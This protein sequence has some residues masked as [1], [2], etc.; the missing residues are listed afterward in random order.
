MPSYGENPFSIGIGVTATS[1]GI[2][3]S[4]QHTFDPIFDNVFASSIA[5]IPASAAT[6][7]DNIGLSSLSSA[8]DGN[9]AFPVVGI[10]LSVTSSGGSATMTLLQ[11]GN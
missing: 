2:I 11:A 5:V 3:Y 1:T 6:W 4:V 7:I 10:R 9:Y 8:A